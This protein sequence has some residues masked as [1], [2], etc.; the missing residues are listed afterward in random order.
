VKQE[1]E[2]RAGGLGEIECALQGTPGRGRVA[3][4]IAR[5]RLQPERLSQP[6]Q[7]GHRGGAVQDRRECCRSRLRVALGEP[8][9]RE[10]VAHFPAFRVVQAGEG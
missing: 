2:G 9:R 7:V 8:Q 4:Q 6:A 3:E 10:S 5:D 1:R